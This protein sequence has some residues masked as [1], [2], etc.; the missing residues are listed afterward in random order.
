[1]WTHRR[2]EDPTPTEVACYWKKSRLSSIG[3]VIKYIEAEKL[4]KKTSNTPVEN[5]PDNST[6]LEEVIQF[7]K[8]QQ[9]NSQIGQS[10]FNLESKKAYNLS[11]HRLIFYFNQSTDLRVEK[12]LEFAKTE[13]AEAV[14]EEAEQ[15]TKQQS[16][17]VTWHEFRYGRIT[18][19]KFYE[20]AHCKTDNGSL[21]QQIIGAS[22]VHETSAMTRGKELEKD[23]IEV[24]EKELRVQIT[25]PGMYL[26]PSYPIFAASPDG[27]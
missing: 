21:V 20:A 5:F 23:V 12:F 24:L 10:N 13:M 11:L 22:K 15:L 8:H 26:V 7:A 25:H 18:A 27:N 2:S 16:E 17:C 6:F 3:T 19:S 1:M 4:T 14:C 9:I